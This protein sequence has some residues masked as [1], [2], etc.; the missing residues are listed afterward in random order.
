MI[1]RSRQHI[2]KVNRASSRSIGAAHQSSRN[3][4]KKIQHFLNKVLLFSSIL[5]AVWI[6]IFSI[7]VFRISRT[8][9]DV[10]AIST[11]IPYETTKIY[12]DDEKTVLAE[13]HQEEN[14]IL[15]PIEKISPVLKEAVIA[16]ED[17]D[18]YS[19]YG[20]NFKGILRAV[21]KDILAR[22]FVE[23]GSTL[24][25]QLAR[26]LFLHR[27]KKLA[28]KLAEMI[29]AVQIE[30]KYTK[31]EILEMYLNQVY[32]GHNAYGIESA[33]Q[34]YFG[35][36][37]SKLSLA[38]SAMLVG[39]LKGPELYSPVKNFSLSKTRQQVVLNRM[40]R[41]KIISKEMA[42]NTYAEDIIITK[43][44][45]FR[46]QAPYFTSHIIKQLIDMYGDE[47]V[48]T[49]GIKVFTTLNY[50]MQK[51]AEKVIEKYIDYGKKPCWIRKTGR[52]P[53]LSYTQA[54]I[55]ALEP[56]TGY[57]KTM[58]GGV[59]FINNQ[60]NRCT[61][62]KRQPGSAFKP[63][64]YLA[65]LEKGFSPG[66]FIDDS[67]VT[68]NTIEGPYAPVNYTKK[69]LGNIPIRV[70]LEKSVNV[71]AIKLN[72]LIGPANVVRVAKTLGISSPLKPVLSLPLGANE[73]TMLELAS[74]FGVFANSGRRVEPSGIIKIED[75]DGNL[76]YEHEIREKKVFDENLI[77][78][79]VDMMK[80]VV[81]FG[82][83]RNAN[84]P[85]PIA[86]KT[87]TTSDYR[88]AWF[89]GFVPQ[90]VCAVWVGNDDNSS[91]TKITG[92]WIPALIWRNFMKKAFSIGNITPQK[93]PAARGLV[94]RK[95]NWKTGEGASELASSKFVTKEKYWRGRE[96]RQEDPLKRK[97]V[98][99]GADQSEN[100]L[101][102]FKM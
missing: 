85:R 87:G 52:V 38:E 74:V 28:R 22:S 86:G 36:P 53:S 69:Y 78:V 48:Y 62:A 21:Y 11:Y 20:L 76:L 98:S 10:D 31:T 94:E 42:K 67:P 54:A 93:F 84:L 16:M 102:F 43:R 17:T 14:R 2:G 100:I 45:K 96:P 101:D 73:V 97:K 7:I 44:K 88:D 34:L 40:A 83:G 70:A 8:L 99:P 56:A 90:M 33:A 13:L 89:I 5:F 26:N 27:R 4:R 61:Q 29:L 50:D 77:A 65:A 80:G 68:F 15:I 79:L 63:F 81:K 64:V 59:D 66:N 60:F 39:M 9:P 92:G 46:Y 6:L 72:H 35:K 55:L 58:V 30:R 95:V 18:F 91:M 23:G 3:R 25:Q 37:A 75:R 1:F 71:A 82:T 32:W 24:T 49:S 47:A 57:I 41:L 12:A 19:H 51:E